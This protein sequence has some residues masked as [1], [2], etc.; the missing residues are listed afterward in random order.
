MLVPKVRL[1][2]RVLLVLMG[3]LD[4]KV[5]LDRQ[6]HRVHVEN[7][8]SVVVLDRLVQLVKMVVMVI[9]VPQGLT[10]TMVYQYV[11]FSFSLVMRL[12]CYRDAPE[13]LAPKEVLVLKVYQEKMVKM[14]MQGPKDVPV[15][16]YTP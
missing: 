10:E 6:V 14:V 5:L 7:Q 4:P 11:R 8:E 13:T 9:G 15:H 12:L 16:R 2:L 1:G 3:L